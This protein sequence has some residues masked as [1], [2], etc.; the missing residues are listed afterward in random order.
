MLQGYVPW[1]SAPPQFSVLYSEGPERRFLRGRSWVPGTRDGMRWVLALSAAPDEVDGTGTVRWHGYFHRIEKLYFCGRQGQSY[2]PLEA[3]TSAWL[4]PGKIDELLE[5]QSR[6]LFE[7]AAG[8]HGLAGGRAL[9]HQR[10]PGM[11]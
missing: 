8:R 10:Q 7:I 11:E 1:D 5:R 3:A 2:E 6:T 9:R 4:A